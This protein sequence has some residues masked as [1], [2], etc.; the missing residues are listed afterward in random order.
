MAKSAALAPSPTA[1]VSTTATLNPGALISERMADRM[2][3]RQLTDAPQ[4]QLPPPF[5]S[6]SAASTWFCS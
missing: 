2:S 1:S 4:L 5:A 6:T 3:A